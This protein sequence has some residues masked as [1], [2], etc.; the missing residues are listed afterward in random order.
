M[1]ESR[2]A[3]WEAM[4]RKGAGLPRVP[5]KKHPRQ[6]YIKKPFRPFRRMTRAERWLQ[7]EE[8]QYMKK[9]CLRQYYDTLQEMERRQ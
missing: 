7:S 2:L 1:N 8:A 6:P 3:R 9:H 5:V 4:I